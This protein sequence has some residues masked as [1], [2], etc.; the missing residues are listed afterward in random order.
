MRKIRVCSVIFIGSIFLFLQVNGQSAKDYNQTATGIDIPVANSITGINVIRL[1]PVTDQVVHVT[2]INGT[3]FPA[4]NSLM[5]VKPS[6]AD[7]KFSVKSENGLVVLSTAALK[8]EVSI[9]TGLITYKDGNG[10]IWLSQADIKQP[11]L[12]PAIFNGEPAYQ[13]SQIFNAQEYE[14]Y[15]GLGQ[16]QQG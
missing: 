2:A 11:A 14:A 7:V 10:K 9:E 6:A 1:Q 16:H 8:V 15:Y 3:V 13:V 5:S 4:E 12:T